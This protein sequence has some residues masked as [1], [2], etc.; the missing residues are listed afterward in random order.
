PN[1]P[2]AVT[3]VTPANGATGVA[4]S[5]APTATFSQAVVPGTVS[6]T[7]VDSAGNPVAGSVTFGGGNTVATVTPASSL[8]AGIPSTATVSGA[9]N[10]SGVAMSGPSSWTFTTAGP[11]C[12][13]SIW[14]NATPSGA[15][16]AADTSAVNL[17]LKFQAATSGFITGIRFY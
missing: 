12:P 17:G 11:T 1:V 13:C 6:F 4:V 7:L 10:S 14:Q 15:V 16:D 5:A 3:G 2:P 8:A 9:Q